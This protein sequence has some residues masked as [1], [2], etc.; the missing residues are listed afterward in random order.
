MVTHSDLFRLHFFADLIRFNFNFFLLC[1]CANTTKCT[2]TCVCVLAFDKH[3]K[4]L[5]TQLAT[6]LDPSDDAK[7]DHSSGTR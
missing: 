6:P 4:E 5:A 7:L 2:P 3:F 1:K